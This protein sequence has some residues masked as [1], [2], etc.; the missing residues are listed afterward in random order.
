MRV[1]YTSQGGILIGCRRR[2]RKL[3]IEVVDSGI[4]LPEDLQ[5]EIF[6]EFF[7]IGNPERDRTQGLGLGLA[8]VQ[9]LSGLLRC[10]I[11]VRSQEGRGA[12]FGVEVKLVGFNKIANVVPLRRSPLERPASGKNLVFVIDD[13]PSVLKGLRLVIED[14]GYTVLTARTE[15]DAIN[16]LNGRKQAPD[17]VIADYR[18]RGIC[19]GAQVVAHI[20]Q[21]FGRPIPCILITGDTAPERIREAND[22]GFTL[23]HKPVE[24]A[25]LH[26]A[27]AKALSRQPSNGVRSG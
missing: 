23:L 1:R 7:Q 19:N 4:G 3:R 26:A 5:K 21:T 14:W 9:R 24:P 10:P 25:D 13:E 11:T 18:L 17:I 8:I 22:H 2:G 16:I 20:R 12:A 27:M 15:L 6:K